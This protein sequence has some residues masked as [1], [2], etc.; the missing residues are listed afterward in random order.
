MIQ[1]DQKTDHFF[2]TSAIFK[3]DPKIPLSWKPYVNHVNY[4]VNRLHFN[5]I[6]I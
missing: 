4:V 5:S 3:S 6:Y 2:S 1:K